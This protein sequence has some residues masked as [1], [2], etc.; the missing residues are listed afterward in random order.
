MTS[1]DLDRF[2]WSRPLT[3]ACLRQF[4]T[5]AALFAGDPRDPQAWRDMVTR[6]QRAKR[7]PAAMSRMLTR[8]LSRRGAPSQALEAVG[9]LADPRT[10]AV[11]T[12][13]QAGLFGGPLYTLLKA[14]T[15]IQLARR[16]EHDLGVRAVP[17]FWVE[18][19]DHDWDEVRSVHILD[20]EHNLRAVAAADLPG[21]GQRP[22]GCLTL[23]DGISATILELV[24]ALPP[25]DFT[26]E[27]QLRLGRRYR[28]GIG[29]AQAFAGWMDD[30]FG[31]H[32][33]VVFEADAVE[34]K[35]LVAELFLDELD[36]AG[37]TARLVGEAG[38]AMKA[39]GHA[40][41]IEPQGD[42]VALFYL[43]EH[44][45][46]AIK[47]RGD[48]FV[49]DDAVR[50]AADVRRE[51][52]NHPERFSPNVL[53]R[54]LV[55]D[56]LFPTVCY[57]A[58]PSELAY[59]A[60]LGGVY[61]AFGVERPLLLPRASATLLDAAALR[62]LERHHLSLE[63]LHQ[64]HE[65]ALAH[66]V[67]RSLPT[68]VEQALRGTQDA[69][70]ER[71]RTLKDAVN[72]LDPTLAGAVDT[73]LDRMRNTL[74][75]LH[76]KIVQA[77]KRNDET[78]RRQFTRTHALVYPGGAP[79]ERVL[80]VPFFLNRYG[81]DLGQRLLDTLPLDTDRHHVLSI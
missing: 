14:V 25:S 62:F 7:D 53:L 9:A 18:A 79:Q 39:L 2:P 31:A 51:A 15:A 27:L 36:H 78:L 34:A 47:R 41:Q 63:D 13:Q 46:V 64:E 80:G 60:Q 16:M 73:T 30:L 69:V 20:G 42:S 77:A 12:G 54:P 8:H 29:M 59:Q 56:R 65:T 4:S 22:I 33:L 66:I 10:V 5:V 19:E 48:E 17:I 1:I 50:S 38:V 49:I 3:T 61:R 58:G 57:V 23:N 71:G 28:D 72:L 70:S 68:G 43:A 24:A 45:R 67:V 32:G 74:Q 26:A 81:F 6:V 76:G 37:R 35:P 55:Q 52:K 75:S 40:P 44:A 21:A 11:V